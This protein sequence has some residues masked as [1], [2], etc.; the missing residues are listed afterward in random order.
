[1]DVPAGDGGSDSISEIAGVPG[2]ESMLLAAINS[3]V[4]ARPRPPRL[5]RPEYGEPSTD[6][7][8]L[9]KYEEYSAG[10]RTL[11]LPTESCLFNSLM[12]LIFNFL[13]FSLAALSFSAGTF[14]R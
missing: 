7:M 14:I 2:A 13:K 3:P 12:I 11:L 4:V 9:L 5:P 6:D 1:M 8:E 10:I